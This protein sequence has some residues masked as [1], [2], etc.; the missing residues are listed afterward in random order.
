[1]G[2]TTGRASSRGPESAL[3]QLGGSRRPR[4]CGDPNKPWLRRLECEHANLRAALRWSLD[5]GQAETAPA[6]AVS[7][8]WCWLRRGY[9]AKGIRFL[10][11]TRS[12]AGTL[13]SRVAVAALLD[14]SVL[15]SDTDDPVT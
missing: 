12:A 11:Q 10:R 5:R 9:F 8:P 1:L 15:L 13:D 3:D 4:R 14:E 6:L 7:P 2:L